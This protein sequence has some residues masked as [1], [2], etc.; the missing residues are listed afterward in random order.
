MWAPLGE[1]LPKRMEPSKAMSEPVCRQVERERVQ[2]PRCRKE[3]SIKTLMY[4]HAPYCRPLPDRVAERYAAISAYEEDLATMSA[5]IYDS[6]ATA[7]SVPHARQEAIIP[8]NQLRSGAG[9][10]KVGYTMEMAARLLNF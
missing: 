3:L 10:S 5:P 2:C 4:K 6:P 7:H 1:R 9:Q 8:A